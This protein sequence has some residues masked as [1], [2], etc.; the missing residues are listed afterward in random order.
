[1]DNFVTL[2]KD[3]RHVLDSDQHEAFY[4]LFSSQDGEVSGLLRLL[5][6]HETLLEL[7]LVR[8]GEQKYLRQ[9]S[10]PWPVIDAPTFQVSGPN[11]T[12][13][14]LEPWQQWRI[15]VECAAKEGLLPFSMDLTF[16]ATTPP[17]CFG[18]DQ[19]YK[20]MQQDGRLTG[21]I[22]TGEERWEGELLCYRD[23]SLGRR[24]MR[25]VKA[26]TIID[27]PERLYAVIIT[28]PND[29]FVRFGWTM[30]AEGQSIPL[31]APELTENSIQDPQAGVEKWT[32]ERLV[33]PNLWY[34]GS[35]GGEET[36]RFEP[37]PGDRFEDKIGPALF[38]S[39]RG[40]RAV[41]FL[42]Q[43]NAIE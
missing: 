39:S 40:E 31:V 21:S 33:P 3:H 16:R 22:Q 4:F 30:T 19:F 35:K 37:Q 28:L 42:E 1:M 36:M 34:M 6:G 9:K 26:W 32:F 27:I 2:Q 11:L 15:R 41:G 10:Q 17:V 18:F 7:V 5:F 14:C 13:D 38:T 12:L 8:V 29:Q 43:S 20:Q 23:H 24:A 25:S